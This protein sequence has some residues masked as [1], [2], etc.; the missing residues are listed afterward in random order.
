[1]PKYDAKVCING[2]LPKE[3]DPKLLEVAWGMDFSADVAAAAAVEAAGMAAPPSPPGHVRFFTEKKDRSRDPSWRM[4]CP[5]RSPKIMGLRHCKTKTIA[6][7]SMANK[8]LQIA[9]LHGGSHRHQL[10]AAML[11]ND[12]GVIT[13]SRAWAFWP[14]PSKMLVPMVVTN[15]VAITQPP[16]LGPAMTTKA[17]A[18]GMP[19]M[20]RKLAAPEKGACCCFAM[21]ST[22]S[23]TI[24][25]CICHGHPSDNPAT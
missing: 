5:E 16:Q 4:V 7:K 12:E 2:T 11:S 6:A 22:P 1:M 17:S 18:R 21:Q 13:Y 15:A 14:R 19:L 20:T 9:A 24:G 25:S 8:L 3:Q 10:M 23:T